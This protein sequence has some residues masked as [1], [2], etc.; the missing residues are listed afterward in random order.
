MNM[1]YI[2]KITNQLNDKS[3]IG[4]TLKSSVEKRWQEHLRDRLKRSEEK[5]P[6]YDAINKYGPEHFLIEEVEKCNIEEV[7]EKEIYWINYYNTYY[8]GYNA[9]KGGDG[10]SYLDYDLI[11]STYKKTQNIAETARI[12]KYSRDS[13]KNIL[14]NNNIKI[15]PSQE[16]AKEKQGKKCKMISP[17]SGEVIKIFETLS[18]ASRY[19]VE[20]GMNNTT[21]ENTLKLLSK[22]CNG[23]VK[24]AYKYIW[25]FTD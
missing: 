1:A 13:I 16:I 18:D 19:L 4:K 20:N 11:I 23:K 21:F 22:A 24:T 8:D 9:T 17:K 7:N 25:Q 2:Y 12:L 10:K 14:E 15:K 6:L 3:Y 5:R